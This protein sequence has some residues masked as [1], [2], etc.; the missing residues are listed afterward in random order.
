M[1]SSSMRWRQGVAALVA[2]P[3]LMGAAAESNSGQG[4]WL[5]E[6]NRVRAELD[7]PPLR[8]SPALTISAQR[9]ADHLART[10]GFE[11][12]RPHR[13]DPDPQGEN[14]WAGT[15][16]YYGYADMV[17]AWAAEKKYFR[18]TRVPN[19]STTGRWEDV[20]HYVQLIWRKTDEVGCAM[21]KSSSEDV[22]V[23]RYGEGG[24]VIGQRPY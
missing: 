13:D 4:R 2:A 8:W 23:C 21:A 24:N 20:G 15:R 1:A 19:N 12:Y 17:R 9:W 18:Y 7:L 22:L 16:G 11:H 14:L 5:A 10:G 3:L 6:H